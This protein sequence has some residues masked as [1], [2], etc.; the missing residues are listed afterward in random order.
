MDRPPDFQD[1]A[2][3]L[4]NELVTNAVLHAKAADQLV[5][6]A[7]KGTLEIGV[8]D[9][10]ARMPARRPIRPAEY[11]LSTQ[12]RGLELVAVLADEWGVVPLSVGKQAWFRLQTP[13]WPWSNA[14]VCDGDHLPR[15]RLGS[16]R[17]AFA[18]PRP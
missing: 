1:T 2:E 5:M 10:S 18:M 14:C 13:E 15:V 12:G 4:V 8:T 9:L 3:L 17:Y 7:A 16:G 6:A 11:G